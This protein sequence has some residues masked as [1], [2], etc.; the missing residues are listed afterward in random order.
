MHFVDLSRVNLQ[1]FH[2]LGLRVIKDLLYKTG[3]MK[4]TNR[5]RQFLSVSKY[6]LCSKAPWLKE[7]KHLNTIYTQYN[8]FVC[9]T[10]IQHVTIKKSTKSPA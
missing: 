3:Y 1:R 8:T 2:T 9:S 6:N 5:I 4:Q 10:T 7:C